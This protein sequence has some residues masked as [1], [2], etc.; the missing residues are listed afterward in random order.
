[1]AF[2]VS[3]LEVCEVTVGWGGAASAWLAEG[4]GV[5]W[6]GTGARVGGRPMWL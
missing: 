2:V 3:N 6:L 1:M 5:G 4:A